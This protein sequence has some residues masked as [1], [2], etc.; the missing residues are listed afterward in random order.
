MIV[1]PPC[2]INIG[3]RVLQKRNDGFHNIE[4]VFYP[5]PFTDILEVNLVAEQ[6]E[7][8]ISFKSTGIEIPGLQRENLCVKAY[9]LL[10]QDY[11]LPAVQV[12]LHKQIPIGAG[13]GGGSSDAAFFIKALNQIAALNL[14]EKDCLSYAQQLGSDCS[15]FIRPQPAL[16]TQKGE[17]LEELNLSLK[18]WH[19]VIVQPA[20]HISTPM[21]YSLIIPNDQGESLKSLMQKPITEWK[22]FIFNAFEEAVVKRFQIIAQIKYD[23]YKSGAVYASMTGSGSAVYGIFEGNPKNTDYFS[24]F[25]VF[26]TVLN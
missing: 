8:T 2:K 5:V 1:Y 26:E 6:K 23:L 21:A 7:G 10:A 4:S 12:H 18:G 22:H 24:N 14:S 19:I 9:Q 20:I 16:A 25:T 3:L 13:L 11:L 15:F 17:E